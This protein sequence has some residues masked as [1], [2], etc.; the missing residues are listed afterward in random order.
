MSRRHKIKQLC[1]FLAI[2]QMQKCFER[3]PSFYLHC[4]VLFNEVFSSRAVTHYIYHTNT[5]NT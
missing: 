3:V 5:Q 4:P 1:I 2:K